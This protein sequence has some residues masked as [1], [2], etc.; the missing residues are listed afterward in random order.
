M[1]KTIKVVPQGKYRPA[2][3]F[4]GLIFTAGMTPRLNGKLIKTGQVKASEPVENYRD[5]ARQAACN[6]VLAA[7]SL[8]NADEKKLF[9]IALTV[10][11]N[12]GEGFELHS[13]V[14]DFVSEYLK[15]STSVSNDAGSRTAVGVA[16]LPGNAP[17]EVQMVFGVEK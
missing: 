4:G 2:T 14:A 5:A 7:E 17:L 11:I 1:D 9:V 16:S 13:K 15:E 3:R 6:A 8:L 10:Y 12:A